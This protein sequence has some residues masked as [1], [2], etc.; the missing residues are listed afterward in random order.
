L[1]VLDFVVGSTA[2]FLLLNA[3]SPSDGFLFHL[4]EQESGNKVAVASPFPSTGVSLGNLPSKYRRC[5]VDPL[6]MPT[7]AA[8]DGDVSGVELGQYQF[9]TPPMT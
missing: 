7:D 6:M 9:R 3:Q 8:D 2:E 4:R 1:K 5:S